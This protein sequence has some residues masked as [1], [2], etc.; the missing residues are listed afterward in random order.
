M[1]PSRRRTRSVGEPPA[2]RRDRAGGLHPW[3]AADGTLVAGHARHGERAGRGRGLGHR[4]RLVIGPAAGPLQ[5][6]L[7]QDREPAPGRAGI[8]DPVQD[9]HAVGAVHVAVRHE[10]AVG[11]ELVRQ[12]GD[13]R[14]VHQLI[15][16][17][18]PGEAE[19][20]VGPQLADGGHG[21]APGAAGQLAGGE[22]GRHGGLA[23]RCQLHPG[24]GAVGGH[25]RQVAR[26]GRLAQREQRVAE[27]R[28]VHRGPGPGELR[29]GRPRRQEARALVGRLSRALAQHRQALRDQ[30]R[31]RM[32]HLAS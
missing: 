21:D 13:A 18:Q 14:L 12:P 26:Q 10:A 32:R 28:R 7:H 15:G 19:G 31:Q 6:D 30:R 23:V 9:G 25:R 22:L 8:E 4:E 5:A 17:Q 16:Q 3:I 20:P 2:E 24:P 29:R 11:G 27:P 1:T